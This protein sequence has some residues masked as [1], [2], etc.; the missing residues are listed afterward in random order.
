MES[1]P[2]VFVDFNTVDY[3]DSKKPISGIWLRR[4]SINED[5]RVA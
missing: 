5:L 2:E 1:K 3:V 4:D